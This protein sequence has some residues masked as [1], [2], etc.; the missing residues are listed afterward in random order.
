MPQRQCL[1]FERAS[2]RVTA[3]R[4]VRFCCL[5]DRAKSA[6]SKKQKMYCEYRDREVI[7]K[8]LA[9]LCLRVIIQLVLQLFLFFY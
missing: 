9:I 2:G 5:C 8:I 6:R 7:I 1:R 4:P 3:A